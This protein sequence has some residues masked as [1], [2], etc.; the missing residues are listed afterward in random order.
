[1]SC[2]CVKKG[3]QCWN[4]P[5]SSD[6][7]R[8]CENPAKQLS[9]AKSTVDAQQG[10]QI[11]QFLAEI[12]EHSG[13]L[14]KISSDH[15][16]GGIGT[17]AEKIGSVSTEQAESQN[18]NS[19]SN[20]STSYFSVAQDGSCRMHMP[21]V[22][23]PLLA[24]DRSTAATM[25]STNE[26]AS[27]RLSA[28]LATVSAD[29]NR[30][31]ELMNQCPSVV[32]IYDDVVHW[33]KRYFDIPNNSTGKA[34]VSELARLLQVFVDSRG[35]DN[36]ALYSFMIMPA[37]LL[38]KPHDK[39]NYR[40]AGQHL[41]RRLDLWKNKDFQDLFAE[42][43]CLQEQFFKKVRKS[44]LLGEE[45]VA[46]KFGIAMSNGQVHQA[47]RML[48]ENQASGVLHLDESVTLRDGTKASVR[49]LLNEKHPPGQ[50]LRNS[51]LICGDAPDTNTIQFESLTP[52]LVA[53]V[54]RGCQGSAGPSGLD[55]NSWRRLCLSFKGPSSAM[56]QAIASFARL[57]ASSVLD[58][59]N[60]VPFLSCRL[61][62]LDKQPG[63]RPIG[64][65]EVLRRVTAKSILK[66][67]GRDVEEACGHLQ[68][69]SGCPAGLEAAVHAMQQTFHDE[70]TEGILLVDAKNAFNSLNR[71]VALHNVQYSCPALSTSLHNCY[72]RPTR[73][74]VSGGGEISSQ[75][76]ITQG[77][78]F[79]MPF[80]ALATLPLIHALRLD[81][82]E[83]R[84]TWLADD[85]AAAGHLRELRRWWDTLKKVGELYGY[86]TNSSKTIL[87]VKD[88]LLDL[89]EEIFQGTGVQ[90]TVKGVRYLG[91]AVGKA[92]FARLFWERRIDD[93]LEELK[94]L[95]TIA[96]TEP[97]AAFTALTHG[98]RSKYTYLLRTLPAITGYLEKV[99]KFL[100]E[101]LL[102]RL[103]HRKT[104]NADDLEMLRLPARLGG[105]GLPSLAGT[106]AFELA[107]S[108]AMTAAQVNEI[109]QQNVDR[110]A[111]RVE[112]V[113]MAAVRARN[114]AKV[115]RQKA[116][117]TRQQQL[118]DEDDTKGRLLDLL[119]K[120]GTSA[121]L[122]TLP[123]RSHGFWLSKWDFKDAL[124][125]RYNWVLENVPVMCVCG[126]HFS[127]DH[128]IVC[129]FGG[130]PS[131]RHNEIRDL[132][133]GLLSEVCHNVA[134]EPRLAP[135]SGEVFEH[136][137]TNTSPEA[138]LDIRARG[139]WSRSED[140]FFDVRIFH[141]NAPSYIKVPLVELFGRHE[142]QKRLEY[143]ERVCNVDHGS[144]SP[145]VFSTT[146]AAGPL[147]DRFIKR[148]ASL[149]TKDDES[150]YSATIAL[151]RCK[152]S[153][154]LIRNTVMCIRGSR[155]KR[156][157]AV[158]CSLDRDV[159]MAESRLNHV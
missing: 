67:V 70:D 132:L 19:N 131:I 76:G 153:F 92:E 95:S 21:T 54:V 101:E 26:R 119:S 46:R 44:R 48:N 53:K 51:A 17:E 89:A 77:D 96:E 22:R 56:C 36:E 105:I 30:S 142:Q 84:Q 5:P 64:I 113:R 2:S 1:M 130:Y 29:A 34:F 62:A 20:K 80:Y 66:V 90:I 83:I 136:R 79:S 117:K 50:P 156:A 73:L 150:A 65:S 140:A 16:R 94:V 122:T 61:V 86:W 127:P 18:S 57:L 139:F 15:E 133:G 126:C 42:G 24:P 110:E 13:D 145:L 128:A 74:F 149:L 25:D 108:K 45:D 40:E 88:S 11:R 121:W 146:G 82:P 97:H 52:A 152:L 41:G 106:A 33:R 58:P 4:C 49:E 10:T 144:F 6:K 159:C 114:A 9:N 3:R 68:K 125:L 69:C 154:A 111:A 35:T 137:S 91:S 85:S 23:E 109:I 120:K 99:D 81:H 47:L 151:I 14:T 158:N 102:P 123:L 31:T 32:S 55:S 157:R 72:S 124:A 118:M 143:E 87:L 7:Y 75:E 59:E 28:Q 148:L 107:S 12:R 93:W 43:K 8:R 129:P 98:L 63:V 141:P 104:F 39:C 60:L 27:E 37:L 134:V 115:Q 78:P 103:T 100:Q 138:R 71:K 112:D 38:Q 135:L 116:E 155:S 147:C